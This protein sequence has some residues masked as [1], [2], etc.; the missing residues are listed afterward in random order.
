MQTVISDFI[1]IFN[2]THAC[3]KPCSAAVELHS[4]LSDRRVW[5]LFNEK[6]EKLC[7]FK[8]IDSDEI[9]DVI[10][11]VGNKTIPNG[12]LLEFFTFI[13]LFSDLQRRYTSDIILFAKEILNYHYIM[14]EHILYLQ[15]KYLSGNI[16]NIL[17]S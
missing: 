9:K 17:F 16:S 14:D 4:I 8:Y 3:I 12:D 5:C 7:V 2:C 13:G 1:A 15:F 6:Y 11:S 10:Y